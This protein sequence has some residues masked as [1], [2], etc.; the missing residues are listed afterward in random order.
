MLLKQRTSRIAGARA[1]NGSGRASAST[2]CSP[3]RA[4]AS[5]SSETG[6]ERRA[7]GDTA[8][9]VYLDHAGGAPGP[10]NERCQARRRALGIARRAAQRI[11][12]RRR[13]GLANGVAGRVL[14]VGCGLGVWAIAKNH[15]LLREQIEPFDSGSRGE[16]RRPVALLRSRSQIE[17]QLVTSLT[18]DLYTGLPN[19]ASFVEHLQ[20]R[21][22]KSRLAADGGVLVAAV[23][24]HKLGGS[25]P[26]DGRDRRRRSHA[27]GCRAPAAAGRRRR[28]ISLAPARAS[29]HCVSVTPTSATQSSDGAATAQL[30]ARFT[31]GQ[32]SY[33]RAGR[34]G[35]RSKQRRLQPRA[36]AAG[37]RPRSPPTWPSRRPTT[38]VFRPEAKEER[39]SLLQLE[40]DLRSA[41]DSNELRLFFQ[42]IVS[43]DDGHIVGFE[44][45]LRWQ[46]PTES[47]IGPD[48]FIPFA[49]SMGQMARISDWVLGQGIAHSQAIRAAARQE[50][51]LRHRQSHA[52]RLESRA[53]AAG[54]SHLLD[55]V[56]LPPQ[57]I[58]IEI[59]ET[60]VVET[61]DRGALDR[62]AQR[63]RRARVARRL[64][65][66][67]LVARA[68]CA[69]CPSTP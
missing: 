42:P 31:V 46:H 56:R 63:A 44:S 53:Y 61:S 8:A 33:V 62:R 34:H 14:A 41:I 10:R 39:I 43:V 66:G 23:L 16:G 64:R 35:H 29:S 68:T 24:L 7:L 32:S 9:P 37:R 48:R 15:G 5:T 65:H 51:H 17:N 20:A 55:T 2:D 60:A 38:S 69:T 30:E 59:T 21:L 52:A 49:E 27:R 18:V 26:L 3:Q 11:L 6:I 47:W 36:G 45:L 40:A 1:S 67:L 12:E 50:P 58:R 54:C 25:R 22:A 19:R 57:C 4:S 13:D 28:R